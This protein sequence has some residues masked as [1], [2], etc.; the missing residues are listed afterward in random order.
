MTKKVY[1]MTFESNVNE[2]I[3][4]GVYSEWRFAF[5][6]M[7]LMLSEEGHWVIE[8]D[9]PATTDDK[10]QWV[11]T[12]TGEILTVWIEEFTVDSEYTLPRNRYRDE[13]E[14]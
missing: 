6:S 2:P 4:R 8:G 11:S 14:E 7:L 9:Y 1:T 10:I 13:H 12:T 5:Q 3:L